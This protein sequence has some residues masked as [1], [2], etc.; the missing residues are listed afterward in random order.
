MSIAL[1]QTVYDKE[2]NALQ[3]KVETTK[4]FEPRNNLIWNTRVN[5]FSPNR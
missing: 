1:G 2:E 3:V 4:V 5:S